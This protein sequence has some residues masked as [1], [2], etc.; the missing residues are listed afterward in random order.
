M[1]NIQHL[2]RTQPASRAAATNR[3]SLASL[4]AHAVF[5]AAVAFAVALVF[6][7]VP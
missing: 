7:L 2:D 4:A 1:A 6:G 3:G 5:M